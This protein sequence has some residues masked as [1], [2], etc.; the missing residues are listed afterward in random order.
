MW[1]N[2]L[3]NEGRREWMADEAE[4]LDF[5]GRFRGAEKVFLEGCCFWFAKILEERFPGGRI[6]YDPVRGHFLYDFGW[7]L[8]DIRGDRT[9]EYGEGAH[10]LDWAEHGD[11]DPV[12]HER[13][14]RQCVLFLDD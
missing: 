13:I 11:A 14:V 8:W 4:I 5:I 3:I 9:G 2:I 1:Y 7:R 6:V 12:H 10:L